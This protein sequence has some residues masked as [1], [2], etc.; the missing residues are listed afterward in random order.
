MAIEFESIVEGGEVGGM[1]IPV[2]NYREPIFAVYLTSDVVG[3]CF[4]TR[5]PILSLQQTIMTNQ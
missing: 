5:G 3:R 2:S 4:S 1:I